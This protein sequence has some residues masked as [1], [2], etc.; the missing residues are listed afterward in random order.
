MRQSLPEP[1]F[2]PSAV[3]TDSRE[4]LADTEC[5]GLTNS[6]AQTKNSLSHVLFS[7]SR[8]QIKNVK[9]H[10]LLKNYRLWVLSFKLQW[11]L[12]EIKSKS[13]CNRWATA[14][15]YCK[16]KRQEEHK[17]KVGSLADEAT[18]LVHWRCLNSWTLLDLEHF[19]I[20]CFHRPWMFLIILV[21][22]G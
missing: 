10:S 14:R 17:E 13:G 7:Y 22:C 21:C 11:Q 9:Q 4:G 12:R 2:Q 15:N 20:L 18:W 3:K 19:G 5:G 16:K 8:K 6:Q 1:C